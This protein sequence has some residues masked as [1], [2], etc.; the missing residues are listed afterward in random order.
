LSSTHEQC[1]DPRVGARIA[2]IFQL[3]GY[4]ASDRPNHELADRLRR[5]N[6]RDFVAMSP[7]DAERLEHAV[8]RATGA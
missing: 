7:S 1:D 8:R 2:L 5:E 4:R 3:A 6:A